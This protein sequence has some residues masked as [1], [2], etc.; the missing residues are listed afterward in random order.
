MIRTI[1]LV[2]FPHMDGL[3]IG[4]VDLTRLYVVPYQLRLPDGSTVRRD[5]VF[6]RR[7]QYRGAE[8]I[9]SAYVAGI[10]YYDFQE[11]V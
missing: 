6:K 7:T 9:D 4:V 1:E 8:A 3:R 5:L 11:M 2:G 10:T